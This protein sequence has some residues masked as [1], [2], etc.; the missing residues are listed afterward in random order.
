MLQVLIIHV[1]LQ[2]VGLT[3]VQALVKVIQMQPSN[4]SEKLRTNTVNTSADV[5][6]RGDEGLRPPKK[7][8]WVCPLGNPSQ[9][10]FTAK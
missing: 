2:V 9:Y 10:W 1:L 5:K 6:S 4:L 7:F 3:Q 8:T